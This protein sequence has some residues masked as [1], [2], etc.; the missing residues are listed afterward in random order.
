MIVLYRYTYRPDTGAVYAI[1]T[2]KYQSQILLGN[3]VA[4]S[5]SKVSLVGYDGE[6]QWK[7]YPNKT[8]TINMPPLAQDTELKWAWA[9]KF[10]NVL[11]K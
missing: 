11:N 3:M 8:I 1:L 9:F 4:G 7:A 2:Q 5:G 10:E 6:V